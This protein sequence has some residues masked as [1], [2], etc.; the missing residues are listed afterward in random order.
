MN[1]HKRCAH[2]DF[3][4]MFA[5]LQKQALISSFTPLNANNI[6]KKTK[7][8]CMKPQIII[9][10]V[11]MSPHQHTAQTAAAHLSTHLQSQPGQ[12][13]R[14]CLTCTSRKHSQVMLQGTKPIAGKPI[15]CSISLHT[16]SIGCMHPAAG[17]RGDRREGWSGE[18]ETWEEE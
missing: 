2:T 5:F 15:A 16:D 4:F 3:C 8:C 11:P 10:S 13:H 7:T 12:S 1:L 9:S 17:G 18:R 14:G 6:L